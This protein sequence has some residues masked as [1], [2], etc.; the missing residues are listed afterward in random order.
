MKS[1]NLNCMA[2]QETRSETGSFDNG[3]ILRFCSGHSNHQYGIEIWINLTVL[4]ATDHKGKPVFFRASHFQTVCHD[5]RKL[6]LRCDTGIWSCWLLAIHAPHTGRPL[7]EQRNWWKELRDELARYYDP[8]AFFVLADANAAPGSTDGCTVF[9]G[10]FRAMATLT[11]SAVFFL[12]IRLVCLLPVQFMKELITL[13]H[14]VMGFLNI[15]WTMLQCHA[16][17]FRPA[18]TPV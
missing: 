10:Q 3:S 17:G 11:N 2:L 13:G 6:L 12:I 7:E 1:F 8:D 16:H 9:Q 4:F 5:A 15:V 18:T 14:I